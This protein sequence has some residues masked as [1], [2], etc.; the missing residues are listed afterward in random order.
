MNADAPIH[1]CDVAIVGGGLVGASLAL[2]LA[3]LGLRIT[4]VEAAR[5]PQ[6]QAAWDERCIALNDA[7]H[8]IFTQLGVWPALAAEAEP[9][10][11]THISERSRFGTARFSAQES[12]L[13]ALGYNVPLRAIGAALWARLEAAG[14]QLRCPARV[15]GLDT[16]ADEV[17][18]QVADSD[19]AQQVL[20]ARLV[21]AADGAASPVREL[22]GI[23][24]ETRDYGQHAI[25]S[26][27]RLSR[28]HEGVAYERFT[29]TGPLALIP[30]P[31]QTAS[32][33]WSL[34]SPEADLR[35]QHDDTRYLAEAQDLLGGRAGRFVELGRRW[36]Y[37]L[38]R[39]LSRET[40]APRVVLLGNAAQSL[41]PVAAQG[42]NLGLR[43]AAGLA[44][45][46]RMSRDPGDPAALATYV[47]RR[48][49][50]RE[51]AA[52]LTDLMVRTFSNRIPGLAQLRHWG[53]V[54]V[55]LMPGLRQTVMR[56]H[57]G[58][59]GLPRTQE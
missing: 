1:D 39:V 54:A 43:D 28:P 55:D 22:L 36:T 29:A 11:A 14:V 25:V 3:P 5:P 33:V 35:M 32:L 13:A 21:A 16:A 52:S 4:L 51:R 59:G 26:A 44:D 38:A 56:Q 20:R 50:D 34:P 41:H 12:G 9:I 57:L 2:A 8:R 6:S 17:R 31:G 46:L 53:L 23:P 18:L 30:K 47:A 37:P 42:F 49:R 7:S 27:V 45:A 48:A 15:V 24:A 10:L 19:G 58:H 40:T